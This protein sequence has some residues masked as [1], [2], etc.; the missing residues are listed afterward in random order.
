[1]TGHRPFKELTK[2]FSPER[3]ARV[4]AR[5]KHLNADMRPLENMATPSDRRAVVV[6]VHPA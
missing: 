3:K 1:M 4:A 2:G 6:S 5:V